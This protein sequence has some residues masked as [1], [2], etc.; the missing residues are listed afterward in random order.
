MTRVDFYLLPDDDGSK[1][2]AA[3]RLAHKAFRLGHRVYLLA[4]D[5]AEAGRLD[6][7]LWTFH[8]GS[9]IPHAINGVPDDPDLPVLVGHDAPPERLNDVLISL[10]PQVPDYF[11]RFARVAELVAPG[12]PERSAARERFRFYRD[13][14]LD[15]Q[16]HNL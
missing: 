16:T 8:P 15:V 10:A 5:A 13:R 7:L 12:E 3:C 1:S 2:L 6:Q 11:E 9:F 4:P 14:G